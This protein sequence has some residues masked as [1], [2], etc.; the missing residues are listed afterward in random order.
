MVLLEREAD[1]LQVVQA[2]C[3]VGRCTCVLDGGKKE[4]H[5]DGDN[6]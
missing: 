6:C 3:P 1:L 4:A 2:A 5:Q